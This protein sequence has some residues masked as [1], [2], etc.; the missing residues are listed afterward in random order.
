MKKAKEIKLKKF[1]IIFGGKEKTKEQPNKD[2]ERKHKRSAVAKAL[3]L[4]P[5]PE[6]E[7]EPVNRPSILVTSPIP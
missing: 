7:P 2:F 1:Y 5:E 3:L 4:E 6:P